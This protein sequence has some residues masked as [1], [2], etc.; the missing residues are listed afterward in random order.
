MKTMIL[1]LMMSLS[2]SNMFGQTKNAEVLQLENK[3]TSSI[4]HSIAAAVDGHIFDSRLDKNGG[5][6]YAIL[7]PK[8]YDFLLLQTKITHW[9]TQF[10]ESS[11]TVHLP[12]QACV[13]SPGRIFQIVSFPKALYFFIIS[14]TPENNMI[15]IS[16]FSI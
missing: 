15:I 2:I 3:I 13:V 1:V 9:T 12:W 7:L 5:I 6:M 16:G 14:Y 11:I 10:P 8:Y 4:S